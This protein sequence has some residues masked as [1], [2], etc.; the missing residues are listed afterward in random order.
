M[1]HCPDPTKILIDPETGYTCAPQIDIKLAFEAWRKRCEEVHDRARTG[2]RVNL[3]RSNVTVE[4][5]MASSGNFATIQMLMSIP[6][7]MPVPF[8]SESTVHLDSQGLDEII[9]LGL[10]K[11]GGPIIVLPQT[12]PPWPPIG[13]GPK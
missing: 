7:V 8:R 6:Q 9:L 3:L 13:P 2:V 10:N 12:N 11:L 1:N 4:L 5:V